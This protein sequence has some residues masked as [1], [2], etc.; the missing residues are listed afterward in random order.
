MNPLLQLAAA[1]AT[2]TGLVFGL[3]LPL[4]ARLRLGA[5]E[6]LVAAAAA[7]V[8]VLYL[9]GLV[10]Y[11]ASLPQAA[12]YLPIPAA[13]GLLAWH[14]RSCRE[15]VNDPAARSM[16]GAWCLVAAWSLGLLALVE[17]YS[18]ARWV[19][20]WAEHH[21]RAR[22]FLAQRPAHQPILGI[23]ALPARPPLA[24]VATGV[25][26]GVAGDDFATYQ[27]VSTLLSSLA[28]LPAWLWARRFA[29]GRPEAATALLTVLFILNPSVAEN[30]TFAWTKLPTVFFILSGLYFLVPGVI[31]KGPER[32]RLAGGFALLAAG[33]L[34]HYSAGPYLV[35]LVLAYAWGHR[36]EW[37]TGAFWRS[38]LA[39]ALPAATLLATWFGWAIMRFGFAGTFLSNT[40]IT[41]S[42]VRSVADFFREKSF[43]LASTIVPHVFHSV[44]LGFIAQAS[45]AGYWRDYFFLLYQ[46]NLPLLCGSAGAILILWLLVREWRETRPDPIRAFWAWFIGCTVVLGTAANGGVNEFG[47]AQLCLQGLSVLGLAWLA[48]R[49]GRLPAWTRGLLAAGVAI[50]FLLGIALH[51]YLQSRHGSLVA[52]R[53]DNGATV[54]HELGGG[55]RANLR[56]KDLLGDEFVGDWPIPHFAVV[57]ILAC[58]LV[59]ALMRLGRA[60]RSASSL[61][62]SVGDDVRIVPSAP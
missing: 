28:F 14:W 27:I 11:W 36:V 43:N 21:D 8:T 35:A 3:G 33:F 31:R 58:L 46:V 29:A 18:G 23:E 41:E 50:D 34:A 5:A 4:A 10:S 49:I 56:L 26:L 62:T 16:L 19:G 59:L 32:A 17:S 53:Q 6:R 20:D 24:N 7:G 22:H 2:F 45:S 13:L 60:F 55:A 51:F 15:V 12:R 1:T 30:S 9:F 39:A 47:I 25:L 40:S 61:A 54:F 42:G 48:G 57:G 37:N 52:F 44:D 38:S